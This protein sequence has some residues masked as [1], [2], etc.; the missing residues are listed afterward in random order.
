M[1]PTAPGSHFIVGHSEF[2]FGVLK[3]AFDPE[4]LRLHEA[5]PFPRGVRR[6]VGQAVFETAV[7]FFSHDQKA[8]SRFGFSDLPLP[9]LFD[10]DPVFEF[11]L[12]ALPYRDD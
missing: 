11:P 3:T 7:G 5:K 8:S 1:M 10:P 9:D 6:G 2:A 12:G 4:A